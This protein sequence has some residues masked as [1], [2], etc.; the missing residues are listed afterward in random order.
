MQGLLGRLRADPP[1]PGYAAANLLHLLLQLGVD[2]RGYDFSQLYFR[3]LY[4]RGASLPQTNFAQAEVVASAFTEPFGLIYAA[5][6]SPD[7][8]YLAAGTSEGAIYLWRTADQQLAQ[9]I[10]AHQHAIRH[11]SVAQWTTAEGERH[12]V[13]ASASDDKSV[14]FWVLTAQ[15]AVRRHLQL[16]HPRQ[17]AVVAVGLH[18]NG[19]R[20]TGVDIDGQV[21][22]WDVSERQNPQLLHHFATAFTRI[23]LVAFSRD[24]QTVVIGHRDGA[25]R[26]WQAA[27]G[28][29]TLQLAGT[30]G[31]IFT[32]AFSRDGQLLATGGREGRLALWRLPKGELHQVIETKAGAIRTLAFSPDGKFLASGHEDLAI[33]LWAIDAQVHLHLQRALLGHTQTIWSVAFGPLPA[34]QPEVRPETT[35]WGENRDETRQLLVT[36]SSDQTVRVWDAATGHTSPHRVLHGARGPL[37]AVAISPDGRSVVAGGYDANIYVWDRASGHLRQTLPGHTNCLYALVFH[38]DGRLLASGS[39]DGTIRLWLLPE[40]E[41]GQGRVADVALFAQPVAVLQADLDVVHT[42]A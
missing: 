24:G 20:V 42:F 6:F 14:G 1:G 13:L 7:G 10:Q 34:A 36:G 19:Q 27:T 33:R 22:V 8:R 28:E 35:D 21:F 18:P 12:L 40:V 9:V 26:C 17:E 41:D 16:A 11:L 3:Q 5:V 38:P 25:V 4:P 37:Y 2:L 23:R 30:T 29:M 32:L 15:G 39:G 31:L